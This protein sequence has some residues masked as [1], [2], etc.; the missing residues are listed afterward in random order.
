M[1]GERIF[2]CPA[3]GAKLSTDGTQIQIKC[4]YCGNT[5]VVP[6]SL[7]VKPAAPAQTPPG[8]EQLVEAFVQLASA[9]QAIEAE[10]MAERQA[11][12]QPAAP[13]RR[14]RRR[15]CGCLLPLLALIVLAVMASGQI[16]NS[17]VPPQLR[18]L[19]GIAVRPSKQEVIDRPLQGTL[20]RDVRYAG[21]DF[22]V[23]AANVTNRDPNSQHRRRATGPTRPTPA[24]S[25][26]HQPIHY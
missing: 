15:G 8:K 12:G 7:R 22:K 24:G 11:Q 10:R 16:P 20:P 1:A 19:L 21:L 13:P 6:D 25:V 23:N 3:C 9:A 2:E 17:V 26:D 5:V 4:E 18:E 14:R